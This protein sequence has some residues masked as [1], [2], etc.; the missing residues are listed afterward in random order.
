ME[1]GKS[2]HNTRIFTASSCDNN[3][4]AATTMVFRYTYTSTMSWVLAMTSMGII[5]ASVLSYF[6]SLILIAMCAYAKIHIYLYYVM[7]VGN[8][9]HRN[10]HGF[11]EID[12]V[13][14]SFETDKEIKFLLQSTIEE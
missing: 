12:K 4:K 2:S 9:K 3:V 14:K 11:R 7:G 8:D 1:F 10:Y 6:F 13:I 5:I